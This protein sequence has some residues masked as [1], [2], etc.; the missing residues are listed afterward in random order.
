MRGGKEG[1]I[2]TISGVRTALEGVYTCTTISDVHTTVE[3]VLY[4]YHYIRCMYRS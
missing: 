2:T 1:D 4:V 3:G